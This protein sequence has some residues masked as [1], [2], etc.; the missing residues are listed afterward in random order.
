M[1]TFFSQRGKPKEIIQ[2]G[3][4]NLQYFILVFPKNITKKTEPPFPQQD[5]PVMN[6][7]NGCC[8]ASNPCKHGE[9]DC[10]SNDDCSG[11]LTCG[12]EN[13]QARFSH[14]GTFDKDD[15]CCV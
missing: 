10:D 9:G 7:D 14:L 4:I 8:T 5:V 15:D 12:D 13:C 2:T 11:S 3:K 1:S 6:H